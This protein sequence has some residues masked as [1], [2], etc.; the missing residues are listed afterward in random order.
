MKTT[1]YD[2]IG[3]IQTTVTQLRYEDLV[4]FEFPPC[5][6]GCPVGFMQHGC[7]RNVPF[8]DEDYRQRPSTCKLKLFQPGG[9]D[10]TN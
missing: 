4:V 5:C 9:Q 2:D 1:A 3:P 7:G 10:E 8:K 6:A